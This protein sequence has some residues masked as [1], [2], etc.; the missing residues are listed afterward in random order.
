MAIKKPEDIAI[1]QRIK[2]IRAVLK[3]DQKTFSSKIN[4]TVSALSN[5]E[6]GRNKPNDIALEAI[7][8]LGEVSVNYLLTGE[9]DSKTRLKQEITSLSS[10]L[11]EDEKEVAR[12]TT[13]L[14]RLKKDSSRE[15]NEDQ[16]D[17]SL[18]EFT[19]MVNPPNPAD[20]LLKSKIEDLEKSYH[21]AVLQRDS[22]RNFL[23]QAKEQLEKL[24]TGEI[25]SIRDRQNPE[26]KKLET[27]AGLPSLGLHCFRHTHASMLFEA[28]ASM[29]EIQVRLGHS[30]ME[31]T[32]KVYLHMTPQAKTKTVDKLVQ[33]A[34]F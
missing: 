1:G 29:K 14:N 17:T 3:M 26:F 19:S 27:E 6:N 10:Q 16:Q 30:N 23:A 24:E 25:F 32:S 4:S 33:F 5:W 21:L 15:S 11:D 7:A 28:G 13:L 22:T 18:F 8:E 12:I 31:M 9:Q 34:N 20:E 2:N